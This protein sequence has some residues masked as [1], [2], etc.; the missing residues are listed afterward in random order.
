MQTKPKSITIVA[1]VLQAAFAAIS[2]ILAYIHLN[3]PPESGEFSVMKNV[4]TQLSAMMAMLFSLFLLVFA[5]F[6]L[7]KKRWAYI[8]SIVLI[9]LSMIVLGAGGISA[10]IFELSPGAPLSVTSEILPAVLL[11][12]LILSFKDFRK[13]A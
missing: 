1:V 2:L 10:L 9:I 5:F 4:S 6:V 7:R 12:L 13:I 3:T 8:T 11:L